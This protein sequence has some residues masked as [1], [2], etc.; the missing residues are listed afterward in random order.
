MTARRRQILR[1]FIYLMLTLLM[2]GFQTSFWYQ[3]FGGMPSPLLWL[4]L[5]VYL[6]VYRDTNEGLIS[7]FLVAMTL[8]VFTAMPEG[9]LTIII[10]IL[11]FGARFFRSRIFWPGP[12]YFMLVCAGAVP[13]FSISHILLS[14]YFEPNPLTRPDIVRW[15]LQTCETTIAALLVFPA[16]EWID[17][18]LKETGDETWSLD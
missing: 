1:L 2:C 3:M 13:V 7:V 6:S 17:E 14:L 10:L 11:F 15:G 4:T 16:Y 12:T 18:F 8:S 9:L 5:I